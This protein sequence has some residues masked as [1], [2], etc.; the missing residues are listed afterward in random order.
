M[1]CALH[2]LA[3]YSHTQPKAQPSANTNGQQRPGQRCGGRSTERRRRDAHETTR[4]EGE[5]GEMEELERLAWEE[6]IDAPGRPP[7]SGRR[8]WIKS[9]EG[10]D[11]QEHGR[12]SGEQN[13][14][15]EPINIRLGQ[16]VCRSHLNA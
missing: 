14:A 15:G 7:P 13:R 6:R 4:H 11:D 16:G 1:G 9:L 10:D 5:R 8:T 3:T 12:D 2:L